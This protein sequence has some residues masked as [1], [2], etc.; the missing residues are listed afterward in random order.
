MLDYKA[1]CCF[2][3][4]GFFLDKDTYFVGQKTVNTKPFQWFY[5]PR[6]IA[7]SQAVDEFAE[8]LEKI[9]KE[10]LGDRKVI[11]PL[12]G[13][14]DSR[15]QAAALIGRSNVF[16]YSY[17]FAH[18]FHEARYGRAIAK[19]MG[20]PFKGYTIPEGYLWNT[21]ETLADW[22]KCYTEFT[23]PRQMAITKEF[24]GMGEVFYLG[25]WGDVLFD[26]M[27]VS[28]DMPFDNQVD[29]VLKKIVKKSGW[30]LAEALWTGWHIEGTFKEYFTERVRTLLRAIDIDNA[31]AC[32]RAFKSMYW[33]PRWT[34]VNLC[35]FEHYH[36]VALPY[37]EERMWHFV[38]TVP[39]AYLSG[40]QIQIEYIKRKA[41]EL[42]RIPWQT[43]TPCNLYNYKEYSTFPVQMR[44]LKDKVVRRLDEWKSGQ[45]CV[46]RN[47]ELQFLGEDNEYQL[48]KNLFSQG[49]MSDV[50]PPKLVHSLY[51][52]FIEGDYNQKIHYAHSVS[53]LL[54]L[55]LFIKQWRTNTYEYA[56]YV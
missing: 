7:L 34:M 4:T 10:Q 15:S 43:Y 5:A 8:L 2:A 52:A 50:I 23:A 54:T 46:E 33:L 32:I 21:I 27:G 28:D 6:D 51:N 25:H 44:V 53:I 18:S 9:T 56:K 16:T 3:A 1:I 47:W 48:S 19:Q 55:S 24:P 42:A 40:R 41:P 38:C 35:I 31:N 13:G 26:D 37:C 39:E 17:Q 29:A 12:S 22:N 11:L 20:W 36:P 14:L 30:E 45:K 49:N